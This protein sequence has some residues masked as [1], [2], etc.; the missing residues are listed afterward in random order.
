MA[1]NFFGI[2]D[3]GKVR[4]NNEDAFIA[5]KVMNN[6]FIIACAID[7]VGGYSGGE[8]AAEIARESIF[9]NFAKPAGNLIE[10]MKASFILANQKIFAEKLQNKEHSKMACVLTL[11]VVDVENNQF[12]YAHVG[13]TRLYLLRDLSLVKVSK[14]HSF[15]GFLEDSG[16]LDENSAMKHLKRN[17]INKALGFGKDIETQDDYIETGS[18][19]FL[20]GDMLLLCSDGLTDMVN[21]EAIT[22]VLNSQASLEE[23]AKLLVELANKN[24]GKDNIT[25]VLVE[26]DSASSWQA[27]PA[28]GTVHEL[29]KKNQDPAH[30]SPSGQTRQELPDITPKSIHKEPLKN[31]SSGT[32]KI[33]VFLCL[34]F[35][36]TSL[37]LLWRTTR[38]NAFAESAE[39]PAADTVQNSEEIKLQDAINALTGDTLVLSDSVFKQ[40]IILTD[41]LTIHND[42]LFILSKGKIVLKADS[43]FR[44][45]AISLSTDS[46][47][48]LLDGVQF[49]NFDVALSAQNDALYLRNV[50]F[51]NC[52]W[53]VQNYFIFPDKQYVTGRLAGSYFFKTDSLNTPK[54]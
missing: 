21:K 45:P 8:I 25:V 30:K 11:A 14:D 31:R 52:K 43:S 29:P 54:R 53:P 12:H 4:D 23:K 19:P 46:R 36:G 40:A 44:G 33:L 37:F 5:K 41:T 38:Q 49:E 47:F 51:V 9:E 26:N 1:E 50:L 22:E 10:A 27:T 2:T 48:I 32:N 3:T 17:E 34:L 35:L 42:S 6:K 15:V 24:G 28:L 16:R 39:I 7:G 20:P 13:D 18:S